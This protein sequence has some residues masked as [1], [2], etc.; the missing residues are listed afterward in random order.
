MYI[1]NTH[2]KNSTIFRTITGEAT[3]ATKSIGLFGKSVNELK[4][5]LS[6]VKTNGILDTFF[7][8]STI[9]KGVIEKYNRDI[10]IAIAN[11]ATMVEKQ[12]IMQSAMDG[13]NKAT[14][15]LI[16]STN[17][18][19]VSTE[20]LAAAQEQSTIKAKAQQ[21]A[22]KG[23]AIAGNMFV[24]WAISKGIELAA[25]AIN[26][27]IHS[28]EIAKEELEKAN[29][30]LE[31]INSELKTTASRIDELNAKENLTL[32][33]AEELQKLK[34][35]NAELERELKNREAIAKVKGEEANKEALLYFDQSSGS[36][37]DFFLAQ[38]KEDIKSGDFFRANSL[39]ESTSPRFNNKI[40]EAEYY[41]DTVEKLKQSL[42]EIDDVD[43]KEYERIENNLDDLS[44]KLADIIEDFME[45][46]DLFIV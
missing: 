17:G 40:N 12:A 34:E 11:N 24:S 36:F 21:V 33:E 44:L 14:A 23:L 2:K 27:Y 19:T 18:A 3:G 1:H 29:S 25:K 15:R 7:N 4:S 22:L 16:A 26:D 8:K 10:E 39:Y 45:K 32:V 6:S 38:F 31:E 43:S 42:S 20:A 35:T 37:A 9:D 30:S 5:I 46:D 41:L 28:L 13:T